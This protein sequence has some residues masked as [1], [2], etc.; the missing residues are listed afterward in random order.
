LNP[1]PEG[2][3]AGDKMLNLYDFQRDAIAELRE[4]FA[5]GYKA[6][7]AL[8]ITSPNRECNMPVKSNDLKQ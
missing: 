8:S 5:K 6:Q 1:K 3:P 2:I 7:A 4:G